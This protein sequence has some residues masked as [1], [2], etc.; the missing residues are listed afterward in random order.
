VFVYITAN[1]GVNI[2]IGVYS[3]I[4]YFYISN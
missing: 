1:E 3:L 4:E 2:T